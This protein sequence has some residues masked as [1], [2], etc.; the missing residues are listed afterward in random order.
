MRELREILG[1]HSLENKDGA[2]ISAATAP[3]AKI[4]RMAELVETVNNIHSRALR[5]E[6]ANAAGLVSPS[7]DR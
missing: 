6:G 5:M 1:K 2:D 3:E 4:Q 7:V